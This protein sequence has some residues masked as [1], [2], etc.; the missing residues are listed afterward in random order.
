LV[1]IIRG[2]GGDVGLSAYDHFDLASSICRFPL[3]VM[4]GV[5]HSTNETVSEM[6]AWKNAITPT[7][8]GFFLV[9][10]MEEQEDRLNQ[11]GM[12]LGNASKELLVNEHLNHRTLARVLRLSSQKLV[13]SFNNHIERQEFSLKNKS[14]LLLH[15]EKKQFDYLQRIIQN[16][17]SKHIESNL[18][19]VNSLHED[20]HKYKKITEQQYAHLGFMA[21]KI[22]LMNPEHLLKKGYS[23]TTVNGK[24]ISHAEKLKK[25]DKLVTKIYKP[26]IESTIDNIQN[27]DEET[28]I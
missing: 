19:F 10:K 8:L 11:L 25:G 4:T 16:S 5:G 13:Q 7:D 6:V 21:E 3:P 1:A 17:V 20:L 23:I 27:H 15:R 22:T 24:L 2:G 18:R 28:K 9:A 14:Q 26:E 12:I